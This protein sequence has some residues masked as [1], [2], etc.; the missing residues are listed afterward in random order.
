MKTWTEPQRA[1]LFS[2]ITDIGQKILREIVPGISAQRGTQ[3][4]GYRPY[5]IDNVGYVRFVVPGTNTIFGGVF[6][7][8]KI[9]FQAGWNIDRNVYLV[10]SF[11]APELQFKTPG[12]LVTFLANTTKVKALLRK[13]L[14]T[15]DPG[16]ALY[17]Q[18]K[19]KADTVVNKILKVTAEFEPVDEW[20]TTTVNVL[21]MLRTDKKLPESL[22][23]NWL[24]S[25]WA[26]VMKLAP[27]KTPSPAPAPER[28]YDP[29]DED[30]EYDECDDSDWMMDFPTE[31]LGWIIPNRMSYRELEDILI[32]QDE[33]HTKGKRRALITLSQS[34]R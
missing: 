15:L 28:D 7:D 17:F 22:F 11:N 8:P 2:A 27:S 18:G 14:K 29:C 3:Q 4:D 20:H 32:T 21:V 12:A 6:R 34:T 31:G 24:E 9:I 30:D 23:K 33:M 1:K 10:T 16:E 25:N 13:G 19:I 5:H 26:E